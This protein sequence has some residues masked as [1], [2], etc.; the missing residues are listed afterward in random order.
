[1]KVFL[2]G[3]CNGSEWRKTII[4]LLEME[5]FDPVVSDWDEQAQE[6]EAE[7]KESSDFRLYVLTPLM[8]G[9][10]SIAEVV[11]DSNKRPAGTVLVVL[12]HDWR[13]QEPLGYE[14]VYWTH[15]QG[16]SI[17]AVTKLV[18][19]NG[20]PCF[21]LLGDAVAYLNANAK[22]HERGE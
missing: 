13:L 9:F 4:P 21:T 10:Y 17:K 16:Q 12:E 5:Y 20:V 22:Y 8:E 19:Q 6:R 2:G 15:E 18:S 1:M 14:K 7:A 11:D 3:T